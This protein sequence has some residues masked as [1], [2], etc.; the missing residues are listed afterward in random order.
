MSE[1]ERKEA[2]GKEYK[3][4]VKQVWAIV[5]VQ[6]I[7]DNDFYIGTM[8]QSKYTRKK[9]NGKD[10]KKDVDDENPY[11]DGRIVIVGPES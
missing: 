4:P 3:R 11:G 7:L 6:G 1:R 9:I 5:T 2:E 8:R 10:V